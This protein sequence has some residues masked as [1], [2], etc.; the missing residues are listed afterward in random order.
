MAGNTISI[1]FKLN[2]D[3]S[4]FKA[5]IKDADGLKSVLSGTVT[6]A[7]KLSARS[8][9]FAALATGIDQMQSSLMQ[10]RSVMTSLTDAYKI[11]QVAETQLETVMRQRMSA[12][13][14]Q[15][16][17]IKTLA[18][19][20]QKLGVVGDE[21]QLSGAQQIAT[22]L[23]ETD[24]LAMLLP[25][26]NNLLAQQKELNA[27][28]QDAVNIG[29]LFGKAM[30]GQTAA[31]R[32]VGITF[33]KAQEEALKYGTESERAA[34]LA[35]IVTDNVGEM[36]AELAKT[37]SGKQ[38]QLEDIM[39][40]LK[41]D[42]GRL[43]Q[44]ALP[45]VTIAAD[46]AIALGSI[47][48]LGAGF[49]ALGVT[50]SGMH[51]KTKALS[52]SVAL[53]GLTTGKSAAATR[54]FAASMKTGAYSATAMKVAVRGLLIATG[55]GVAIVAATA[56]IEHFCNVTDKAAKSTDDLKEAQEAY[57]SAAGEAK[58]NINKEIETLD[59]LIK[60]NKDTDDAVR[61]LNE[62]YGATF[63]MHKTA[64]DWYD[65][66]IGKSQAYIKQIGYE[67]HAK[68]LAAKI[69]EKDIRRETATEKMAEMRKNGTDTKD[70]T[71]FVG[72]GMVSVPVTTKVESKEYSA[73]GKEVNDLNKELDELNAQ[74]SK[75][76]ERIEACAYSMN[77]AG[78]VNETVAVSAMTWQEVSDAIADTDRQLK[79]TLS[80]EKTA[81]LKAYNEQLKARKKALDTMLGIGGGSTGAIS[82]TD[83]FAAISEKMAHDRVDAQNRTI[84]D[85]LTREIALA[86]TAHE[87]SLSESKTA[88]DKG[89]ALAKGDADKQSQ[90]T[91]DYHALVLA[92]DTE[93]E[94][95][96][97]SIL[98]KY[99]GE[100]IRAYLRQTGDTKA[101]LQALS[102]QMT[103]ATPISISPTN[104]APVNF[105]S[106]VVTTLTLKLEGIERVKQE[107]AR[108]RKLLTLPGVTEEQRAVLNEEISGWLDYGKSLGYVEQR[109]VS[110]TEKANA[111]STAMSAMGHVVG[112]TSGLL[113]EQTAGWL[114]WGTGVLSAIAA[115]IPQIVALTTTQKA[116][117][118]ANS[119]ASVTGA[120]A[121]VASIPVVGWIMAGTAA[122]SVIAAMA[123]IP[124]F[125][126]GGIA[127]GP[128]LGMFGE[129]AGASNNPEVVAP[130]NKLRSLLGPDDGD[131]GDVR[132]RIEGR[133]LVGILEKE[134]KRKQR[135]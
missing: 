133:A 42:M 100:Q 35:Q 85:G 19:E 80:P 37:D 15:I 30:Q 124:K 52:A 55:A 38:K 29:N 84:Q 11:Q 6:E 20:Q 51:L 58:V 8:I 62:T 44:G 82:P 64:A 120:M 1:T 57:T 122:A 98:K 102:E 46:S 101:A 68:V 109:Q 108:L 127:Y 4:G 79:N 131:G 94:E 92:K 74:L 76:H 9:N 23:N 65:T 81:R 83:N 96:R 12:T 93:F 32:R 116:Q 112:A 22:F 75:A 59:R 39:G 66:L 60:G 5:L 10:L 130:L 117:A 99:S 18:S 135:T 114:N 33:S 89:M 21:V 134:N 2:G 47:L 73:L 125:A 31:L 121:S 111:T 90:L 7:Q 27:T 40:D 129:Y 103:T 48:K 107:V 25:A 106:D 26:L 86:R 70:S 104:A 105:D 34:M 110:A 49:K 67:A 63:G 16:Q 17:S 50:I 77:D 87:R 14:E 41:E 53:Y 43:V 78:D 115:A 3:N 91:D 24:S 69:A 72:V 45:F 123:S 54:V 71:R 28:N 61:H 126:D 113:N 95:K 132:F 56:I 119:E 36:N 128:T 118:T 88:Y 13:D 97:V